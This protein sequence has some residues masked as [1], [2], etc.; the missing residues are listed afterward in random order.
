MEEKSPKPLFVEKVGRFI[1]FR[2]VVY[3]LPALYAI[4][5]I[6]MILTP[7]A[8]HMPGWR[9]VSWQAARDSSVAL[10]LFFWQ[11]YFANYSERRASTLRRRKD[12]LVI[13]F[14]VFLY[15]TLEMPSLLDLPWTLVASTSFAFCLSIYVWE[16]RLI[17]RDEGSTSDRPGPMGQS[18]SAR[19]GSCE[20]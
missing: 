5:L 18:Q 11:R 2:A 3:L 20:C 12:S 1:L 7:Q 6:L 16:M 19:Q 14:I 9:I 10:N 8:Y 4:R 17:K 13:A 15:L